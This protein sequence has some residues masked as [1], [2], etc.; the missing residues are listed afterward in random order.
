VPYDG[1]P[2][3]PEERICANPPQEW[4]GQ[5]PP[6]GGQ[7][8]IQFVAYQYPFGILD[9]DYLTGTTDLHLATVSFEIIDAGVSNGVFGGEGSFVS[10][11]GGVGG[12]DRID[13]TDQ[14]SVTGSASMGWVPEPGTALLVGVGLAG[15]GAV[16]RRRV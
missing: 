10:V 13:I 5:P 6:I 7:V 3:S 12:P 4:A 15:L 2:C 14:V 8:N 1:N 16:S 9:F 11:F